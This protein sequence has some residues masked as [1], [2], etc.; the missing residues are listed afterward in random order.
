MKNHQTNEAK[1]RLLIQQASKSDLIA[2]I[3]Y[4]K[5]LVGLKKW[6][7]IPLLTQLAIIHSSLSMAMLFYL[8]PPPNTP[9]IVIIL[10]VV[11]SYCTAITILS[12]MTFAKRSPILWIIRYILSKFSF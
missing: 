5:V 8:P 2:S 9:S 4:G 1:L 6:N 7:S 11:T 10:V 3:L 12:I